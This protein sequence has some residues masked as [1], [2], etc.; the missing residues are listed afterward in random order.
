MHASFFYLI[1]V[2]LC[3]IAN[4]LRLPVVGRRDM[5][6]GQHKHRGVRT[7]MVTQKHDGEDVD[8]DNAKDVVVSS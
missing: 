8:I 6:S 3:G 5:S 2:S 4:A 7:H 1:L